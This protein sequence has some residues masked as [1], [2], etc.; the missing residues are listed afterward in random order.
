MS[1]EQ[2]EK[3][4]LEVDDKIQIISEDGFSHNIKILVGE[5]EFRYAEKISIE[6]PPNS[7]IQAKLKV[8][9]TKLDI[10]AAV[11]EIEQ[12]KKVSERIKSVKSFFS[13]T[14]EGLCMYIMCPAS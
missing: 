7:F 13:C 6:I 14:N 3:T 10:K 1:E 12:E 4:D 5:K 8:I 11:S 2:E 9:S